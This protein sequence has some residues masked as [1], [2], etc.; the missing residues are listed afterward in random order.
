MI[1]SREGQWHYPAIK[2]LSTL[3]RKVTSKYHDDFYCLNCFHSFATENKL[4]S[5]EKASESKNFSYVNMTCDDT[6]ILS[7]NQYKKD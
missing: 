2:K 5:H 1:S 4:E 6:K 7:F 3:L